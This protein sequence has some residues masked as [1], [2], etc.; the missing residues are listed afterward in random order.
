MRKKRTVL[1]TLACCGALSF[2]LAACVPNVEGAADSSADAAAENA[3]PQGGVYG[4]R[5]SLEDVYS[6]LQATHEENMPIVRTL[7]D[8]TQVQLV[9]DVDFS[10]WHL[11]EQPNSYNTYYLN[12]ENRGCVSCHTDGLYDL[13]M[14][15]IAYEHIDITNN[16]GTDA[17]PM[18]CRIC[19]DVGTGYVTKNFEFGTLIH[20]IHSE[21]SFKGDCMSCHTATA[22]GQGLMLWE[23]AKYSVM[24][25]I[26]SLDSESFTADISYEQETTNDMFDLTFYTGDT[27]REAVDNAMQGKEEDEETFNN[28]EISVTGLV[29]NPFTMTLPELIA[30]APSETLIS[31]TQCVMNAP[32]GEMVSNVEITGI[33]VSWLLD[34]AGVQDGATALMATAPDGWSRGETLETLAENGAYLVYEI[35][36]ERLSWEDG[37]PV[38]IWYQARGVPSSIRWT[39]EL[40]VVDTDPSEVTVFEGW[41]LDEANSLD[42]SEEGTWFNKPNAGIAHFHEGQ[43]IPVG[44]AYEFE[45]YAQGYDEQIVSVEFSLDNGATWQKLDTSDSDKTKWVYWHFSFTPEEEGSYVLSVR[46]TTADGHVSKYPDQVMFN[47]K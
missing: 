40:E 43:I 2:G 7:E 10:Y 33:P 4:D 27:N 16:M 25:G 19:H 41:Q 12:A 30:E 31:T 29:D 13:V 22:D 14:N 28:W 8:G 37:Y 38:R 9:P 5:N 6:S 3:V 35:N 21:D 36:G 39:S 26:T 45:G 15:N 1:V 24:Q 34:K 47:A 20:G 17:T 46:A 32:G 23:E 42:E 44:E 11:S 18:D